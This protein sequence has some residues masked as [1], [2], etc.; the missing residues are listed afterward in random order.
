MIDK[1]IFST[2]TLSDVRGKIESWLSC[3]R[4]QD[5]IVAQVPALTGILFSVE[6]LT[7]EIF[8]K[9][10]SC[11]IASFFLMAHIFAFN[12]WVDKMVD[13]RDP[14][15]KESNFLSKRIAH[16]EMLTISIIL[17]IISVLIFAMLSYQL[18]VLSSVG[19]VL[20]LAYS[21]PVQSLQGKR[22]PI[23]SSILHFIGS[24]IAFLLGYVLFS[25]ID[26]KGL[27]IAFYFSFIFVAGHLVQEVQDF[28]G[29]QKNGIRTHAVQFGPN[30]MFITAN[31][32]FTLSFIYLFWL[33]YIN[34]IPSFL[35]YLAFFYPAYLSMAIAVARKGLDYHT[36]KRFRTQYRLLYGVIVAIIS[37]SVITL[38]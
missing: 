34:L 30:Q 24:S 37:L 14:C 10:L 23:L 27:L 8:P 13:Y 26:E 2:S 35:K 17:G 32:I 38:Y 1:S 7:V 29:D 21:F 3:I 5:A 9:I 20:S 28:K 19:I 22:I 16:L 15:K 12:D 4:Y 18:L 11:T 33:G 31:I 6:S 36:I 25:E